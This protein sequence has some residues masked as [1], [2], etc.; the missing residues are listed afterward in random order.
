M[1]DT[2]GITNGC[3]DAQTG[4][5]GWPL[6]AW[7]NTYGV[8]FA[9]KAQYDTAIQSINKPDGFQDLLQQCRELGEVGDPDY[10]GNNATVNKVCMEAFGTF[11]KLIGQSFPKIAKVSRVQ[12]SSFMLNAAD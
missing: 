9:S 5:E 8:R 7:N 11:F 2:V 6:F 4:V 1:L 10:S 3:V 12:A